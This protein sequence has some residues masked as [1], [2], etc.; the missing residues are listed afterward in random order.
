M[1]ELTLSELKQGMII[2]YLMRPEEL[3]TYPELEWHGKIKQVCNCLRVL[4]VEVLDE[5][6]EACDEL[7][8]FEQVICVEGREQ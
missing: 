4:D 7:V 3:P 1:L 8:Y 5:G 6:Y 2:V